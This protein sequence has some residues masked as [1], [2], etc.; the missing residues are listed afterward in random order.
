MKLTAHDFG[1]LRWSILL[2]VVLILA[3]AGAVSASL[4]LGKQEEKINKQV[5]AQYADIQG[6]LARAN[7]ERTEILEKIGRY[8]EMNARGYIGQEHRL[9]W[10]ERIAQIKTQRR[11]IDIQYELSPQKPV[12]PGVLPG[13]SVAGGYELMASTMKFQMQLLHED[14]LLGFL[15]DLVGSVQALLVPRRCD[16]ERIPKSDSARGIAPQLKADCTVEWVTL[17]EKK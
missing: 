6:K 7:D 1:N 3:G 8:E 13:G 9:E 15:G 17:R 4:Y 14:D 10:V 16:V 2:C 11:L 5:H 12:D